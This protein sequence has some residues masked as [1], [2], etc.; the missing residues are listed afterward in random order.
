MDQKMKKIWIEVGL[1]IALVVCL[2]F[3]GQEWGLRIRIKIR[4]S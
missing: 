3:W 2:S 1:A 4:K